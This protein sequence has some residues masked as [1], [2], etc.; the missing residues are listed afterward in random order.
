MAS[1]LNIYSLYWL[2][3]EDKYFLL[4]TKRPTYTNSSQDQQDEAES[5]EQN[6]RIAILE[7]IDKQ[8]KIDDF[9]LIGEL[10]GYPIGD[11][12]YSDSGKIN[13]NIFYMDTEFGQPWIILGNADSE[14]E[15]LDEVSNDDD[16]LNLKPIGKP[17]QI[18]VTFLTEN[19]SY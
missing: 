7:S 11:I 13:L 3:S 9:K 6:K 17:K 14:S 12:L 4:K 1:E 19:D 16:L 10:Q 18:F 15:F 5:I 8:Y 2:Q